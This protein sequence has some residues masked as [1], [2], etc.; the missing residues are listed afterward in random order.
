LKDGDAA[1]PPAALGADAP[2]RDDMMM[3]LPQAL[4]GEF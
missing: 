2:E 4:E 1:P 3:L